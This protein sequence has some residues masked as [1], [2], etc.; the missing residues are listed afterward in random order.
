MMGDSFQMSN[1]FDGNL[2][3]VRAINSAP[4]RACAYEF[5][6]ETDTILPRCPRCGSLNERYVLSRF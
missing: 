1:L 2:M 3:T 5:E 6:D 4:P